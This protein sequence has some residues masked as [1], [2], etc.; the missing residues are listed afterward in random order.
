MGDRLVSEASYL[1]FSESFHKDALS[2]LVCQQGAG[3]NPGGQVAPLV[4][5]KLHI[6][7]YLLYCLKILLSHFFQ[8]G[9]TVLQC[10]TLTLR[11]S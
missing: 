1:S 10:I 7:M 8:C 3:A 4:W 11:R 5:G 2:H 6:K 9:F